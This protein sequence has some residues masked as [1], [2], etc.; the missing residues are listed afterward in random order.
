MYI[1]IKVYLPAIE[2]YVPPEMLQ[3]LQ[4]LMDFIYIA[5]HDIIDA[6]DLIALDGALE[7]FHKYRTIFQECGIRPTGFNLPR[8]HSLIHYHT[9]IREFGAP[10]GLCSSITESKHIK[11]VKEPW[12]RSSRFNALGQMLLINQRLDNL[13]ASRV[14]FASRGM[15]EGTCLSYILNQLGMSILVLYFFR[16]TTNYFK[17]T[18]GLVSQ[19]I[20]MM[21]KKSLLSMSN[22][23]HALVIRMMRV[24]LLDPEF[25]HIPT[26]QKQSVSCCSGHLTISCVYLMFR[27]TDLP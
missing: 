16:H 17:I 2:G 7:R 21:L 15:L 8:Q 23:M 10:N 19:A 14:D 25:W 27:R 22:L 13:A 3:A 26:W 6:N 4:A 9:H 12:R 11:A 5:R 18:Q 20:I 24:M 1:L